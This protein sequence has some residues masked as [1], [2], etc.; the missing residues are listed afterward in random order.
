MMKPTRNR[1]RNLS[2]RLQTTPLCSAFSR[3]PN[4]SP[5]DDETC[6]CPSP[7]RVVVKSSSLYAFI[8]ITTI[9]SPF[10]IEAFVVS[11]LFVGVNFCFLCDDKKT[12]QK[13]DWKLYYFLYE[14]GVFSF[15]KKDKKY[16]D[17]DVNNNGPYYILSSTLS[18]DTKRH[19][20]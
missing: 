9:R 4:L 17:F 8:I 19:I 10:C 7:S 1:P 6:S 11:L 14:T 3:G 16:D 5:F 18:R 2:R 12:R 15:W 13:N 20:T